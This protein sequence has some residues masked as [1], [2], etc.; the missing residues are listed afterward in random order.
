MP[1]NQRGKFILA[2]NAKENMQKVSTIK[3]EEEKRRRGDCFLVDNLEYC[4]FKS[5][6]LAK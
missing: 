5:R 3:K 2:R 4:F 1:P 6:L